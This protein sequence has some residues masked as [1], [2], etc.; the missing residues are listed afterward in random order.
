MP[1]EPNQMYISS[2][3]P[4]T[5]SLFVL[6][7]LFPLRLSRHFN[8]RAV[9]TCDDGYQIVGLEQVICN[10]D[11]Q[12]SGNQPSCKQAS[13]NSQSRYYCGEPKHIPNAKHNG[14]KE[15]V[16]EVFL[17]E[18]MFFFFVRK[19][20]FNFSRGNLL[21]MCRR[22]RGRQIRLSSSW[23]GFTRELSLN[24][25]LALRRTLCSIPLPPSSLFIPQQQISK[26]PRKNEN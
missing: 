24:W 20:G 26:H 1:P 10:S 3:P 16:R 13:A 15:Q 6:C 11:G 9:Y 8:D 17:I 23:S 19:F 2:S 5:S 18:L 22:R 25:D 12:W 4:Q 21:V 14:S 7:K